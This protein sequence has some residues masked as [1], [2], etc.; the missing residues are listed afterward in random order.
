MLNSL[1]K[2]NFKGVLGNSA[3]LKVLNF[4]AKQFYLEES[5]IYYMKILTNIGRKP[6]IALQLN[7]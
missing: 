1:S 3:G 6:S 4:Y 7:F 2:A 5:Y